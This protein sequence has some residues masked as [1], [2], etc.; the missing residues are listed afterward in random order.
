M[1]LELTYYNTEDVRISWR[2]EPVTC[3]A[4]GVEIEA[5]KPVKACMGD[6]RRNWRHLNCGNVEETEEA[7]HKRTELS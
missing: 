2:N 4:C 1:A 7:Y 5:G 3:A 6:S